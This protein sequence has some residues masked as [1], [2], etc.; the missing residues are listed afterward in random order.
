MTLDLRQSEIAALPSTCVVYGAG[1]FGRSLSVDLRRA[2]VD[3]VALLDRRVRDVGPEFKVMQPEES[4][5]LTGLPCYVGVCNPEVDPNEIAGSA[6]ALGFRDIRTP[7]EA[8]VAL[9]QTGFPRSHYWLTS[10]IAVYERN[11][12]D[13]AC[14]YDLL[15]DERSRSCF[16]KSLQYRMMGDLD[17]LPEKV[18]SPYCPADIAFIDGLVTLIDGGAYDGDTLR[19]L[20]D[21]SVE[22]KSVIAFEPDPVN[23]ERL[24]AELAQHMNI[25]GIALPL[26]LG[27]ETE[28]LRFH[29]EGARSSAIDESGDVTVQCVALD[30]VLQGFAPT[31]VKLDI[32]G[33]E[34]RA[35]VGMEHL[36]SSVRPRLAVCAYHSPDHLW[37]ILLQL[38]SLEL[39]YRF[40]LR[41][42]GHQCFETI[43]YAI[44]ES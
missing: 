43:L 2:G 10:E 14:A 23:F 24:V 39:G 3:V 33:Q 20:I 30:D 25:E 13:I 32:E 18:D 19:A 40:Y 12:D 8:F 28:M 27:R 31:H 11:A 35:L 17:L 44:P 38:S 21:A 15:A 22:L 5:D 34:P 36:L 9:G 37:T 1:S 29:A 41:C 42:H 26:A 16:E 4:R 7:V 6:R